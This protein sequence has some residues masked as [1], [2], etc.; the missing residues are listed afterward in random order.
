M[1]IR[2]LLALLLFHPCVSI[3][4]EDAP[5]QGHAA[6]PASPPNILFFFADDMDPG[7]LLRNGARTPHIDRIVAEGISF[8][9]A[10]NMGGWHGAVCVASRAMLM[11]GASLWQAQ[12]LEASFQDVVD[13]KALWP[14]H[15]AKAGYRTYFSGKWH[16]PVHP[17]QA[18]DEVRHVR[19]GMPATVE[20][21]YNRPPAEGEDP[22]KAWDESIGGFWEGGKHWSEVVADDGLAFLDDAGRRDKPFFM[23][24]SFNA[25][26]D[27]RQAPQ[28]YV[29]SYP[30][31]EIAVPP[32]FL[33]QH[34]Y[35]EAIGAGPGLRDERLAPFPRTEEAIQVH[36]AEYYAI[37]E[38]M[39]AQIGRVLDELQ[40][41]GLYDNTVIV[42]TA[43]HG[44]ACGQHGFL[45]KQNMYEHSMGAP[46]ILAGPG[47]P[48]NLKSKARV[49]YQDIVPTLLEIAGAEPWN[50]L[51]FRS[52]VPVWTA[53]HPGRDSI[54]GAYMHLQRMIIADDFKLIHYPEAEVWRLYDL[55]ADPWE[56]NDL[57]GQAE[58][59]D[60]LQALREKLHAIQ[61]EYEDPAVL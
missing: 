33:A 3:F 12:K 1:W 36:L 17:E 53:N 19:G 11:T 35:H 43:D 8:E 57:A 6:P 32:N 10:Y 2:L 59:G 40:Q 31:H 34:P 58:H 60:R 51:A 61:L 16:L 7:I 4:A 13:Q 48:A 27:P 46:L 24:L 25:P 9:H 39:D 50:G 45:G 37:I 29:D 28:S 41:S 52:L 56:M 18:F 55:N 14:Q 44:L 21:A 38:H 20:S 42:F 22:W 49:Y 15:M 26:H 54:Y 47:I 5:A 30:L 23:V